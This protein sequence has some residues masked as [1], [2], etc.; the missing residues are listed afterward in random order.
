MYYS[1]VMGVDDTICE[2]TKSEFQIEKDG[3]NYKVSFPE[4][5]SRIWEDYIS[6]HLACGYWNEYLIKNGAVF[7]FHLPD[8]IKKYVVDNYQDDEVLA[9]CEKLC[10]CKFGSLKNMLLGNGFYNKILSAST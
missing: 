1:Y 2:L 9:L 3:E 4:E 8:G 5:K 10:G 6:R 7:L